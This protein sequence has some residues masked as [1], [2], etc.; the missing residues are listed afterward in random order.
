MWWEPP[1]YLHFLDRELR[2]S[3]GCRLS[4]VDIELTMRSLLL[5]TTSKLYCGLSLVWETDVT[6]PGLVDLISILLRLQVLD[7]VSDHSTLGEFL[8][9]RVWIYRHDE[10]RYPMYFLGGKALDS[11]FGPTALKRSDT[12]SEIERDMV[13]WAL[14]GPDESREKQEEARLR[15][16]KKAVAKA[17]MEREERA[18][19]FALFK[20]SLAEL[21]KSVRDQGILRRRISTAYTSHYLDYAGG[22]IP[23]GIRGLEF[24]DHL[25]TAFPL[26]D[27]GLIVLLLRVCGLDRY[28]KGNARETR[29][30]WD[31]FLASRGVGSG[32]VEFRRQVRLLL[33]T[34]SRMTWMSAG[35]RGEPGGMYAA[36]C[37][38]SEAIARGAA[39]AVS[40]RSASIGPDFLSAV[41]RARNL[42]GVLRGDNTFAANW[43]KSMAEEDEGRCDLLLVVAAKVERDAVLDAARRNGAGVSLRFG[44][45][46]T[47]F[48]LGTVGGARVLLVQ[49]EK[50]SVVPGG[51]LQ[52]IEDAI[53]ETR[54][55]AV[56]LLGIAFGVN[57]HEQELAEILV[58]KQLQCYEIQRIGTGSHSEMK[59]I[60]RGDRVTADTTLLGR[61]R[62]ATSNWT[63]N[64]AEFGLVLSGEKLVDNVDFRNQLTTFEPEALGGEMEGAGLYAAASERHVD[65]I[66]V[67]AICDW[68]DGRKRYKKRQRQES[69]AKA[70]ADFVFH[71]IGQGGFSGHGGSLR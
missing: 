21:D 17:L 27:L 30:W 66:I 10:R 37:R 3:V 33:R 22:E 51:S 5:G 54:P 62:A 9:S 58:S 19:T 63:G 45:R 28:I 7:L 47:Y 40:G 38:M 2:T 14:S 31:G 6:S 4:P 32:H 60:P 11:G 34:L 35:R 36:R 61:F 18:V 12:T 1:L 56:I 39:M 20:Q 16:T 64:K 24:F 15:L 65:W 13:T 71:T 59:I 48:T 42:V 55:S 53:D 68:A 25:S 41:D 50:G 49:S 69:A 46:R 23:T 8:E 44:V 67:K 26:Y 52:T 57:P 29:I 43:E 70:A